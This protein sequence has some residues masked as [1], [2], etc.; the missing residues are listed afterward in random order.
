MSVV[1]I[2]LF[3]DIASNLIILQLFVF[4]NAFVIIFVIMHNNLG[5][6]LK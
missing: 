1:L 5:I 6:L 4:S 2:K 3:V